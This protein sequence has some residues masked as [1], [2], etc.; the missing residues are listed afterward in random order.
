MVGD[1]KYLA[2]SAIETD[3]ETGGEKVVVNAIT[4]T[5]LVDQNYVN[6]NLKTKQSFPLIPNLNV[7]LE[8]NKQIFSTEDLRDDLLGLDDVLLTDLIGDTADTKYYM[9]NFGNA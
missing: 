4:T 5:S 8:I 7:P 3:T 2:K 1:K 6:E 9:D